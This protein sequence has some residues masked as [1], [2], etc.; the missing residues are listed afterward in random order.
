[1]TA[2]ETQR[3]I[4]EPKWFVY[5]LWYGTD[6]WTDEQPRAYR[7]EIV[8]SPRFEPHGAHEVKGWNVDGIDAWEGMPKMPVPKRGNSTRR[9]SIRGMLDLL[10]ARLEKD[11]GLPV[12]NCGSHV[13]VKGTP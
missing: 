11:L 12:T 10:Q 7:F 4:A 9:F 3:P 8:V 6:G 13:L 1:M 2:I 5:T